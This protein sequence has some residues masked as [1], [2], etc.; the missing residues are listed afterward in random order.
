MGRPAS[1]TDSSGNTLAL[2]GTA[3]DWVQNVQYDLAGRLTSMQYQNGTSTYVTKA[4]AYNTNGQLSTLSLS[5]GVGVPNGTIQYQ[6]STTQNNGQ[7]TQVVDGISGE[8]ITYQYD[9]LKRVTQAQATTSGTPAP[10]TQS[11]T[12]DGF[13]NLTAK[14][15]N[16]TTTPIPVNAATNQ[17]S[18]AYYDANGNMTSGVGA[19]FTYDESNRM[20]SA[21]EYSGGTE[22]YYY[23]PDNKRVWDTNSSGGGAFTLY[24]VRGEQLGVFGIGGYVLTGRQSGIGSTS[25]GFSRRSGSRGS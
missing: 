21:T 8:T 11:Y 3:V 20:S 5:G 13:G 25:S 9:L 19:T 12:Y 23:A 1:L 2:P 4:M 17:L 15:L 7:V 10:W 22:S 6:Y 24:G 18:S 14:I 16:G